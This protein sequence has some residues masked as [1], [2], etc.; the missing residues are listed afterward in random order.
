V[1]SADIEDGDSAVKPYTPE[2][3]V[4]RI[5]R[6]WMAMQSP[7]TQAEWLAADTRLAVAFYIRRHARELREPGGHV[8]RRTH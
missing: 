3:I 5:W 4:E 8:K 2:R 6:E 1:T 7:T